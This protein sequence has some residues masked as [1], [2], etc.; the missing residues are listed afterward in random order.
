MR[1]AIASIL[2]GLGLATSMTGVLGI[3]RMPDLYTR[4]QCS[5]TVVTVG[6]L[7]SLAAVA[8][9]E[10]PLTPFGSRAILVAALLLVVSPAASHALSRAAYKR[11]VELW[12]GSIVDQVAD[13]RD[14][15][16]RHRR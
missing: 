12:E 15:A 11:G 7:A 13:R 1:L 9:A 16:G 14:R 5:T 3:L 6:T 10:G 4:I 8:V 2:C